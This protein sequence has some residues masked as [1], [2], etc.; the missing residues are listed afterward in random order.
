MLE[1]VSKMPNFYGQVLGLLAKI[2]CSARA[3][4]VAHKEQA[5]QCMRR[6]RHMFSPWAGKIPWRRDGSPSCLKNPMDGGAWWAH[7]ESDTTDS[8]VTES[9]T[10]QLSTRLLQVLSTW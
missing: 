5:C 4:Q 9:L 1:N 7:R 8:H 2:E 3:S 6:K 10:E